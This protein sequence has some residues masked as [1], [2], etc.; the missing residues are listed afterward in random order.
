MIGR[1]VERVD[2]HVK[3]KGEARFTAEFKIS[4]LAHA[5]LVH[6]TIAKGAA[7]KI[8]VSRAEREAGVVAVITHENVPKMLAPPTMDFHN[9]GRGFA[10]SDLP[11]MQ[12]PAV[13]WDGQ[14]LAIVVAETLEQAE[15]AA[16]LVRIEYEAAAP[17][18]SF[19]GM[20]EQAIVPSD[21]MGEPAEIR[22][23]DFDKGLKEADAVVANRYTAPR[24]NHN[25]IEPHATIAYW[26]QD[27]SLAVFDSTQSVNL[28]AH[29]LAYVFDLEPAQVRV[30]APFVGGGFG[31]KAGL[32]LLV[33]CGA[34]GALLA[35]H[36]LRERRR[37]GLPPEADPPGDE[38]TAERRALDP[39]ILVTR[40]PGARVT[41][42]SA[43]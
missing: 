37:P 21:V 38:I 30:F 36:E 11:I 40:G 6:A 9:L 12:G 28:T 35:A 15:Y 39:E 13:N 8:D 29:V 22:A 2:G 24:Y 5:V 14:P 32:W 4:S 23:G 19:H 3:V 25:A 26:N 10:L 42:R 31:G 33:A 1:P 7:S 17:D 18:V 34:G 41:S 27:G 20:K 16:S 43:H